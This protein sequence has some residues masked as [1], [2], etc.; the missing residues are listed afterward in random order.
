MLGERSEVGR[1]CAELR[2]EKYAVR[3]KNSRMGQLFSGLKGKV[4]KT[5]EGVG[6]QAIHCK[7][8]KSMVPRNAKSRHGG[9]SLRQVAASSV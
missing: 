9:T 1:P 4:E 8:K 3:R 7:K 2:G 6:D 5:E